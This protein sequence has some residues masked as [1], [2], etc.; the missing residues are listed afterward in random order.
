MPRS[1]AEIV[2]VHAALAGLCLSHAAALRQ[3]GAPSPASPASRIG[4]VIDTLQDL[5]ASIEQQDKEET[6]NHKS[7]MQWCTTEIAAKKAEI[8][9]AATKLEDLQISIRQYNAKITQLQYELSQAKEEAADL[10]DSMDQATNIRNEENG[11]YTQEKTLNMQSIGQLSQAIKIVGKVHQGG[12]LQNAALQKMQLNEPGESNFVL[13]VMKSLKNTMETNQKSADKAEVDKQ[14]LYDKL[15]L[16]KKDQLKSNQEESRTKT[17]TVSEAETQKAEA[18]SDVDTVSSSSDDIKSYFIEIASDCDNKK[19]EWAVRAEDRAAE[20]KA[21]QEAIGFL[22]IIEEHVETAPPSFLQVRSVPMVAAAALVGTA[23]AALI[24]LQEG[25]AAGEFAKKETF[26]K[27][28]KIVADLVEL[29]QNEQKTETQKRD[30]CESE[31]KQ[32]G[33]EKDD[34]EEKVQT[35]STSIDKK[36]AEV[37]VSVQEIAE[38]K[39]AIKDSKAML[40]QAAGLRT[41]QQSAFDASSKERLLAVK[42]LKQARQ[43]L[44]KFYVQRASASAPSG[45][46][47]TTE[48]SAAI[49]MIEKISEDVL[50]EQEDAA[51]AEKEQAA[52]FEKL[53][54][55]GQ[56]E[57]DRRM[58][59]IT[60]RLERKAKLLVQ[61]DAQKESLS[62]SNESLEAVKTQIEGLKSDCDELIANH[63]S[64]EKARAFEIAQLRDVF[65]ILSGS[66]IAARTG[67]LQ[68]G[69][70]SDKD[71]VSRAIDDLESRA[72]SIRVSA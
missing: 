41:K 34:N 54:T 28:K 20:K 15:M 16:T 36:T 1:F 2:L 52:A 35:L 68:S 60:T 70:A 6:E 56:S 43:V 66:E 4:A 38:L 39:A 14:T 13:G 72:R 18:T 32:K 42:V 53:R 37:S 47:R 49:A 7:S 22:G 24:Q 9:E 40:E 11:K 51:R 44:M 50:Q 19:R 29:L 57:F 23:D 21:I 30:Y 61:M 27:V 26:A 8:E 25:G 65:D 67:L 12:F 31:L 48:G 59:E 63:D 3:P 71:D 46:R 33:D 69:S 17:I 55:D 62:Q 10:Q 5:L 58:R 45:G 64:R